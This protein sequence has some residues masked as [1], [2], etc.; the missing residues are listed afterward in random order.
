MDWLT[1]IASIV[2]SLAWPLAVVFALLFL[3]RAIMRVLLNLTRLKWKDLELEVQREVAQAEA[4]VAAGRPAPALP[5]GPPP[6]GSLLYFQTLAEVSPRAAIVEG[7][8]PFEVS[9]NRIAQDLGLGK[10]GIALPMP[11]LIDGLNR[12]GILTDGEA[13]ALGRLRAV[14]NRVVHGAEDV[15]VDQGAKYANLL[16]DITARMEARAAQRH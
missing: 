13:K 8:I 6:H 1:F 3:R 16:A 14:R 15:S 9:A 10:Q 11:D 5:P 2:K 4:E 12:E 7:W